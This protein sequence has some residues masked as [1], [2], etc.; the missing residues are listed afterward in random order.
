MNYILGAAV[1]MLLVHYCLIPLLKQSS[2][3]VCAEMLSISV[4]S[5]LLSKEILQTETGA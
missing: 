1:L 4:K 3:T 5:Y 2:P